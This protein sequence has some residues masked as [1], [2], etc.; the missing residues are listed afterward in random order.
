MFDPNQI[1]SVARVEASG[2]SVSGGCDEQVHDS[3]S[4]LPPCRGDRRGET[5]V[6]D[7]DGIVDRQRRK[8]AL[9]LREAT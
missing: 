1:A 5:A 2:M 4:R 9:E 7:G 8:S 6:T 3:R